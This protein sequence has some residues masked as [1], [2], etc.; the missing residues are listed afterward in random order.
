MALVL[1]ERGIPGRTEIFGVVSIAADP[2]NEHAEF[3]ILV[4]GDMT[5]MGLGIV[6]MRR[7]IDYA[8]GRGIGAI[9]G[10]VLRENTTMLRL[11]KVFGF[12]QPNVAEESG[13]LRA[14]L[15]L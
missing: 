1:T 8:R 13:I 9:F 10:D 14:W 6:L 5:G 3:A 2:D 15:Q 4:R 11:C 12:T 7:I